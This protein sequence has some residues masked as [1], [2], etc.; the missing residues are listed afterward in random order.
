MDGSTFLLYTPV[1]EPWHIFEK[2]KNFQKKMMGLLLIA[3]LG[4]QSLYAHTFSAV[5]PSGH[6]LYYQ[7]LS[8]HVALTYPFNNH[9]PIDPNDPNNP[10][11]GWSRPSGNITIPSTVYYSGQYY[12]VTEIDGNTFYGCTGITSVIIPNSVKSIG[13]YAFYGCT[14][15]SSV[16]ISDSVIHIGNMA[17]YGCSALLSIMI[18]NS[19]IDIGSGAFYGCSGISSITI[20][21]SVTYI[22]G[23][24][25]A[26]SAFGNCTN[27]SVVNFNA[28]NCNIGYSFNTIYE[29]STTQGPLFENCPNLST[30]NIGNNV[31]VIPYRAF[32]G[33]TN[34]TSIN[35]DSVRNIGNEAFKNCT[36]LTSI[37]IGDSVVYVG[38]KAFD[39]CTNLRTINYNADSCFADAYGYT[40]HY[41]IPTND[42]FLSGLNNIT[43]NIGA[44]VRHG[45]FFP[46]NTAITTIIFHALDYS[47][48][49]DDSG[50]TTYISP[51]RMCR[52]LTNVVVG[53]NVTYIQPHL[54]END[55]N[56]LSVS[57]PN[58]LDS[59][60][61]Y[62]FAGCTSMSTISFP[63]TLQSIGSYAFLGCTNL[64]SIIVPHSVSVIQEGT[65]ALCRNLTTIKIGR[66]VT[67]LG[68][69]AFYG[70]S[71]LATI[72]SYNTVAPVRYYEGT[73]LGVDSGTT[74][75]IPCGS[76]NS[77]QSRWTEFSNFNES[78]LYTISA[79]SADVITGNVR[80]LSHPSCTS[81]IATVEAIANPGYIFAHWSDGNTNNPRNI[82]LTTDTTIIAYFAFVAYDT[83]NVVDTIVIHDTITVNHY[84]HDTTLITQHDTTYIALHDTI[85]VNNYIH[86]TTQITLHDTTI[87]NNYIH[88]TILIDQYIHDT[89]YI[90]IHDTTYI[91][92]TLR[93]TDTIY[94]F[95]T[96]Y[97]H[98]TIL[99]PNDINV[100]KPVNARIYQRNG[101]IIVEGA[102]GNAVTVYDAVGRLLATKQDD[103]TPLQFDIQAAGLYLVRIGDS[104][105]RR[106]VVIR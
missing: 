75:N 7:L 61:N 2:M 6:T 82:S 99:N 9:Y 57:L 104:T 12:R 58:S 91:V 53:N 38:L 72:T 71:N 59:I 89:I 74:I 21:N 25:L 32:S 70:D 64:Q 97:I 55:S 87:I 43:V 76:L 103:G 8:D 51:F 73:F 16:N 26:L 20:P 36:G 28:T 49:Y 13:S 46:D 45:A 78:I 105:I 39:G 10:Y 94:I 92:D 11:Y 65:F 19:V 48:A 15:L 96:I 17:F 54:F 102:E 85:I 52:N 14:G 3:L 79:M 18:P 4:N 37:T 41:W 62:A 34:I 68:M 77:Y 84:F 47:T 86:D 42:L 98:D 60:G 80:Y 90:D 93:L 69:Y 24:Y 22:G 81:S 88:D 23:G 95:D 31:Q 100:L 1:P 33:C 83:V 29:D 50:D 56:L 67:S 106:V 66:S 63:T 101:Q 40:H 5:S 30:L 44:G 27:L 35:L